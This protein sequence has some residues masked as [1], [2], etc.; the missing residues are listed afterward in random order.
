MRCFLIMK[1]LDDIFLFL[2]FWCLFH[3]DEYPAL[4]HVVRCQLLFWFVCLT[5]SVLPV[6]YVNVWRCRA[7]RHFQLVLSTRTVPPDESGRPQHFCHV[8]RPTR[9]HGLRKSQRPV[10]Q[11]LRNRHQ[12]H[13]VNQSTAT[14]PRHFTSLASTAKKLRP[15]TGPRPTWTSST[16]NSEAR[17]KSSATSPTSQS[18]MSPAAVPPTWLWPE[19]TPSPPTFNPGSHTTTRGPLSAR[20]SGSPTPWITILLRSAILEL[21]RRVRSQ[22]FGSCRS[23]TWCHPLASSAIQ[24]WA[25]AC[26]KYCSWA[27]FRTFSVK[28]ISNFFY[29]FHA[30]INV[31]IPLQYRHCSIHI[32]LAVRAVH[33][34]LRRQSRP[35]VGADKFCLVRH[36]P[37]RP[38]RIH[39]LPG[40]SPG[41]G[42]CLLGVT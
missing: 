22:D 41:A 27:C 6:R 42:R 4:I 9:I 34:H 39:Q 19:I 7:R 38:G 5:L 16:R 15:I 10:Q 12:L 32:R 23:S 21:A 24:S 11:R 13:K 30:N 36:K 1:M 20:S 17:G 28:L 25:V 3:H 8:L 26:S 35:H 40:Q 18:K 29:I 37:E 31:S 14:R 33:P 2:L